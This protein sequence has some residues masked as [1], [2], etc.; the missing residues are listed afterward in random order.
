MP[1]SSL[2]QQSST[3]QVMSLNSG[4]N[5]TASS[6]SLRVWGVTRRTGCLIRSPP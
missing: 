4:R 5:L 3:L 2:V 6:T 1:G